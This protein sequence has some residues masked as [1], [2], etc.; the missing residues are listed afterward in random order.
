[1]NPH[2]RIPIERKEG[3]TIYGRMIDKNG[4]LGRYEVFSEHL[5]SNG[6]VYH[7]YSA[8]EVRMKSL[9]GVNKNRL[10]GDFKNNKNKFG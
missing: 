4:K 2:E 9:I 10:N 5:G 7:E 1:M 6:I 3:V 8:A